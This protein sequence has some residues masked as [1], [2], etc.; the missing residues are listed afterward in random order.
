[1]KKF[2]IGYAFMLAL[3]SCGGNSNSG[4]INSDRSATGTADSA[5]SLGNNSSG[6][7]TD[8]ATPSTSGASDTSAAANKAMK[9][10]NDTSA[11][12]PGS[13]TTGSTPGGAPSD[14]GGSGTGSSNS[15]TKPDGGSGAR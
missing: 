5:A 1:M 6:A 2:I 15:S 14:I 3:A 7:A 10:S 12:K 8:M 4:N 13:R 9:N 11:V